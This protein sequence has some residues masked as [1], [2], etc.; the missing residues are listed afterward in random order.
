MWKY[1]E[2]HLNFYHT[3]MPNLRGVDNGCTQKA[4]INTSIGYCKWTSSHFINWNSSIICLLCKSVD[5]LLYLSKVHLF[6]ITD[7]RNYKALDIIGMKHEGIAIK[8]S[9]QGYHL[10]SSMIKWNFNKVT[11]VE[12]KWNPTRNAGLQHFFFSYLFVH[13]IPNG[14][15]S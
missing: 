6:S 9:L 5:F 13:E 7:N 4:S 14:N 10:R 1:M 3:R 8:K 12:R 15:F 2:G 11:E